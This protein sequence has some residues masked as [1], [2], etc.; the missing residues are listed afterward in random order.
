MS[1]NSPQQN[2]RESS[3]SCILVVD[4]DPSIRRLII[5]SLKREGYNFCEA[6]NGAEAMELMR[7]QSVDLVVLDLMMPRVSGWDVLHEREQDER[8]RAI[9][10]VVVSASRGPEIADAVNK[11]I[12]AYLPKPFDL[13]ALHS[14]VRGC[15]QGQGPQA[16]VPPPL[17]EA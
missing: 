2:D 6:A 10:V 5:A 12:C 7:N 1:E 9:P 16:I 17:P 3:P 8:L 15:L 4:D 11:G 14:L 13:T